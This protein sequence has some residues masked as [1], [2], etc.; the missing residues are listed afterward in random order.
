LT[1]ES[2]LTGDVWLIGEVWST[3][4]VESIGDVKLIPSGWDVDFGS[5]FFVVIFL[6]DAES[7]FEFAVLFSGFLGLSI[8]AGSGFVT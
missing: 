2:C 6:F 5:V 8:S 7:A 1:G 4:E 3:G